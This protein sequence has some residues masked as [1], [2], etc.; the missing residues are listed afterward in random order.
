MLI[1]ISWGSNGES[2]THADE[3]CNAAITEAPLPTEQARYWQG[4]SVSFPCAAQ[5]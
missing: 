1:Y 2:P 4:I 3:E 5:E